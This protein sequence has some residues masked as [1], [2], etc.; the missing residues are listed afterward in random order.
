MYQ[1]VEGLMGSLTCYLSQILSR[2]SISTSINLLLLR[3]SEEF[4]TS[5]NNVLKKDEVNAITL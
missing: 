5:L 1:Y 2:K 3:T 4:I